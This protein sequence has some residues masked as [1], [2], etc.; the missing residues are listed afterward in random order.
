MRKP[1]EFNDHPMAYEPRPLRGVCQYV[2]DGDTI[3]VMVDEGLYDYAYIT[4]RLKD[5]DAPEI[6]TTNEVEK[7]HGFE[8]K[9]YLWNIVNGAFVKILTF[10]DTETFGR[11][12]ADVWVW[13]RLDQEWENVVDLMRSAGMEKR[14]SY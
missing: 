11:F 3:D 2:V 8:A 6:R 1:P 5:F 14:A 10:K 7:R 12:V 9:D 4:I 13:N